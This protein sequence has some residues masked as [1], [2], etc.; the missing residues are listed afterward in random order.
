MVNP[1]QFSN[2]TMKIVIVKISHVKY[3]LLLEIELKWIKSIRK[4][5]FVLNSCFLLSKY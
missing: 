4:V 2:G 1:K 5:K 3:N